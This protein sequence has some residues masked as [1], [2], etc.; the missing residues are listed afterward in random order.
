MSF[1]Q[2]ANKATNEVV[3]QF[4]KSASVKF[5]IGEN[6]LVALWNGNA[7]VSTIPE[8]QPSS[9][10]QS[11]ILPSSELT[12]LG[13][14]ELIAHCK[15]RGLK[16]T[17]NKQELIE[18]LTGGM[19]ASES[20]GD[21]EEKKETPK[22]KSAK[23]T[24]PPE[25][26]KIVKQVQSTI[27]TVQIKKNAFN[28]FEH[29]ETGLVFDRITQKVLGKQNKNGKIDSLTDADIETCNKYK[30][31][32]DIPENLNSNT[33]GSVAIEGLEE[34]EDDT[35][36]GDIINEAEDLIEEEEEIVEDDGEE[37]FEEDD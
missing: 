16:T 30:F 7:V 36:A 2:A 29:V 27:Q 14:N 10:P 22:K 33:K 21:K 24:T 8:Q 6:E 37:F 34:D 1:S 17:G 3:L 4:L 31:K 25:D 28:N 5:N 13:K 20:S 23:S 9:V 15:S 12:K 18:R 32:Y 19:S 11:T 35:E 26:T